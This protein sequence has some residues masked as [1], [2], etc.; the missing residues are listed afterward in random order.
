MQTISPRQI[1]YQGDDRLL[2]RKTHVLA[3]APWIIK[4]ATFVQG[5][6]ELWDRLRQPPPMIKDS[7]DPRADMWRHRYLEQI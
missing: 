2:M 5:A 7:R 6:V 3:N 1:I 4:Q